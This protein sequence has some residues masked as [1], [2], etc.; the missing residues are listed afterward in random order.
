MGCDTA[1]MLS[2]A[3]AAPKGYDFEQSND[4]GMAMDKVLSPWKLILGS[5]RQ[6][7]ASQTIGSRQWTE[8]EQDDQIKLVGWSRLV[9]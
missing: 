3:P 6:S 5:A 7:W 8:R 1:D 9:G 2:H 4:N